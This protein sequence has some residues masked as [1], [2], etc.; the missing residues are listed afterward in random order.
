MIQPREKNVLLVRDD[1]GQPKPFTHNLPLDG[2]AYGKPM[3]REAHGA[4]VLTSE[5]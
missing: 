3:K 2:H 4:S 1:I 5:W